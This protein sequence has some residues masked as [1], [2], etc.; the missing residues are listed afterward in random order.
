MLALLGEVDETKLDYMRGAAARLPESVTAG[1]VEYL[2]G[3]EGSAVRD[4]TAY[5][6][7][8]YRHELEA[9]GL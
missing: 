1:L 5:V 4:R 9:R 3:V 7:G 8:S 6:L 2:G